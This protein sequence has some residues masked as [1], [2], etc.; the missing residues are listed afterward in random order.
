MSEYNP[1]YVFSKIPNTDEGREFVDSMRQHLNRDRY[2]M[3]VRGQG[4][5]EGANW[6]RYQYGT[7][8]NKS[9]HMRVYI[10]EKKQ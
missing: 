7:P 5:V 2:K 10:E 3:R 8:L 1:L 9:T 6:R 4:L